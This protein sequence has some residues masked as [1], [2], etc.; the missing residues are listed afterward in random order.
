ML[1]VMLTKSYS[2]HAALHLHTKTSYTVSL[3]HFPHCAGTGEQMLQSLG[4]I[5]VEK[6][7]RQMIILLNTTPRRGNP[8]RLV[9]CRS[10]T[11]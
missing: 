6:N 1:P 7:Y 4:Q 8:I 11:V 5:A 2:I 3:I 9:L 10:Y